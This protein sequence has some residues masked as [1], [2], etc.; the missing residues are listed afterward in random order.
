MSGLPDTNRVSEYGINIYFSGHN[1]VFR[2]LDIP[3]K[4]DYRYKTQLLKELKE[5]FP[6]ETILSPNTPKSWSPGRRNY[7]YGWHFE[8]TG[9]ILYAP[10]TIVPTWVYD[11]AT[12][13]MEI[14]VG[15]NRVKI[16][17]GRNKNL[18]DLDKILT[19]TSLFPKLQAH[20]LENGYA[21]TKEEAEKII[22]E[23]IAPL[24]R[25]ST[26]LAKV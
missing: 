1:D 22:K 20:L 18:E 11:N 5:L 9:T 17:H 26:Q 4:T 2:I 8:P 12:R 14:D 15:E 16:M 24:S 23:K 7:M 10:K 3:L 19:Q 6:P 21:K 25:A 13:Y